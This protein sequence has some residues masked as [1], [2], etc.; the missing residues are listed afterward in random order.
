MLA[1]FYEKHS[2]RIIQIIGFWVIFFGLVNL[3]EVHSYGLGFLIPYSYTEVID[4]L[5]FLILIIFGY[6]LLSKESTVSWVIISVIFILL[7]L[8]DISMISF[9]YKEIN[10]EKLGGLLDLINAYS[11]AF[12]PRLE[13]KNALMRIGFLLP[14]LIVLSHRIFL[15]KFKVNRKA[16]YLSIFLGVIFYFL[17]SNLNFY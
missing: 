16:I 7:I 15:E 8:A 17:K 5:I 12:F 11:P 4:L 9:C 3:L 14:I 6:K 2:H 13:M 1:R 10:S